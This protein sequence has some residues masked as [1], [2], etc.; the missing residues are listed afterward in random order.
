MSKKRLLTLFLAM[1]TLG[2]IDSG[3]TRGQAVAP[4]TSF[5]PHDITGFWE[6]SFDSEKIPTADLA[7][8]VTPEVLAAEQ[9]KTDK[10]IRWCNQLGLPFL[11]GV[12]RPLDIRQGKRE[13]VISPE[14]AVA[15]ARHIYLNR[16]EHVS[17]D[18]WD[19]SANGDS[20]GHWESDTLVVDTIGFNP[21][22]G[23]TLIPGGGYRS[24]DA[25]L[26]ERFKLLNNGAVLDVT[27]T[28][29]DPKVYRTP[30]TY[31]FRYYKQPDKYEPRLPIACNAFDQ[32][33]VQFLGGT[34][35][36]ASGAGS[37]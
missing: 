17:S 35:Q 13:I 34:M 7:S 20:I 9:K 27:F 3:R 36:L 21:D 18:I 5:D 33:R 28:W 6:L 16:A 22:H 15:A 37:R 29:T 26:V 1:L 25:H 14:S 23:M 31:E 19:P 24:A 30:H 4:A 12:S 2:V 10:A 11:M 32:D 8:A